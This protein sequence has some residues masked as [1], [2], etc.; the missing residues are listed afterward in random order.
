MDS[1][2]T[3][4]SLRKATWWLSKCGSHE[5]VAQILASSSGIPLYSVP[6]IT[7]SLV[8]LHVYVQLVYALSI[9][10]HVYPHKPQNLSNSPNRK[11]YY[12]HA[13]QDSEAPDRR[14]TNTVWKQDYLI[15]VGLLF[16]PKNARA[17][18]WNSTVVSILIRE[19]QR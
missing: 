19:H 5:R 1:T 3:L 15:S 6:F 16:Q 12:L 14:G 13:R 2:V 8:V 17:R 18:A 11:T 9:G 7:F 4:E 10:T